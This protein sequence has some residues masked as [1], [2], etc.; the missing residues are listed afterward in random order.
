M[1]KGA[2]KSGTTLIEVLIA[3]T[4]LAIASAV[5]LDAIMTSNR[6]SAFAL[7]RARVLDVLQDALEGVRGTATRDSLTDGKS[8]TEVALPGFSEPITLT[9]TVER[10]KDSR[11][12]YDVIAEATWN[13]PS[14]GKRGETLSL[15]TVVMDQ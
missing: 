15:V 13:D 9:T 3:V 12:C 5:I 2:R 14:T 1:R 10:R 11:V 7:R 6:Q 8:V 4:F